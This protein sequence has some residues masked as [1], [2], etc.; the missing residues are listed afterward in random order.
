M[1]KDS[2]VRLKTIKYIEESKGTKVMD[3]Y[4]GSKSKTKSIELHQ[5]K[6]LLHSK[7]NHE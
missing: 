7:T 1:I 2:A 6:K 4:K 3:L 5:T